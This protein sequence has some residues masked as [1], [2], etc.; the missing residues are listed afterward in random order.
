MSSP[1]KL[2]FLG[3]F[4]VRDKYKSRGPIRYPLH[5]TNH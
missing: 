4:F 1:Q 3:G 5:K 2:R